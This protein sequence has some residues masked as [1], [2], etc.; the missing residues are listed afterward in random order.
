[1]RIFRHY[2][3]VPPD[4]KGAVVAVG[5]FDGVHRGHAALIDRAGHIARARGAALGVLAFE[6]HPREFFRPSPESFRLTPFRS[7]AHLIAKRGVDA[8]FCL[9][10]DAALAGKSAQDFIKDVLVDGLGVSAVMVGEDFQFGKGRG[11]GVAT[12]K[13]QDEFAVIVF[14]AVATAGEKISSTRIREALKGGHPERAAEL[15]GHYWSIEGRVE[16]GD[17]RGR[18]LGFPT[19]NM[20]LHDCLEPAFGVYAV[21]VSVMQNDKI[22]SRHEGV[23]NFGVR[24]MFESATPLLET[25]LFDFDGDLYGAHLAVELV[26]YLRGEEK[27]PDLA[28]LKARI[29][30]DCEMARA[31]LKSAI[32]P[33]ALD[34]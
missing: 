30:Q 33:L 18:D 22:V 32:G 1:M 3:D 13:A 21:R 10:F 23:A 6:P 11:G 4:L 15:L 20:R 2:N 12:L 16:H 19:A 27:L 7:K 14:D 25:Y 26:A 17:G 29:A 9:N 8:L 28:A 31:A 24:P 34:A 5:N